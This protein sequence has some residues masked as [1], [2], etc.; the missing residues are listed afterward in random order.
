MQECAG[1]CR[2]VCL[3]HL[4]HFFGMCRQCAGGHFFGMFV[5]LDT[6]GT[7]R[8]VPGMCRPALVRYIRHLSAR[9]GMCR[10]GTFRRLEFVHWL[11]KGKAAVAI[12]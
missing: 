12:L 7:F 10:T 2:W 11:N 5:I 9:A 3:R 8:H 1:I 6:V 4:R